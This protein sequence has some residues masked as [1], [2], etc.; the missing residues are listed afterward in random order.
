MS[1]RGGATVKH[2][3]SHMHTHTSTHMCAHTHA[4]TQIPPFVV[5][6][7]VEE[8]RKF[9]FPKNPVILVLLT[10]VVGFSTLFPLLFGRLC[11]VLLFFEGLPVYAKFTK[12]LP[13]VPYRALKG[14]RKQGAI[15]NSF[16][17]LGTYENAVVILLFCLLC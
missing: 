11:V 15:L 13:T 1:G 5:S 14:F 4:C 16:Q 8:D 3:C 9:F 7:L 6:V 17:I 12:P 2:T 10:V